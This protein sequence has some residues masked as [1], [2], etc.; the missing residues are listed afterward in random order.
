MA[1]RHLLI[2][3]AAYEA[4]PKATRADLHERFAEWLDAG[5]GS[6]GEQDEIVGYHL[7]Q[8]YR[9]RVELGARGERER[10]LADA[11]GRR[12]AAAGEQ[13]TA[14]SD[15]TASINLL[16]RASALLAPDDPQRL[17]MLAGPRV[18]ARARPATWMAPR[19]SSTKRSSEPQPQ[20][21]SGCVCTP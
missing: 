3:D 15:Y 10:Q 16:S 11:A 12:L 18:C 2:R 8:A 13:A 5:G 17:G 7:E 20:V 21:M 14:R 1:F 19:P 4:I 6:L 9:Y